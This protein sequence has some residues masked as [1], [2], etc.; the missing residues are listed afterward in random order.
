[1]NNNQKSCALMDNADTSKEEMENVVK[2]DA[3]VPFNTKKLEINIIGSSFRCLSVGAEAF[4]DAL[5]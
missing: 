4:E 2:Q 3:E 1:M 5:V